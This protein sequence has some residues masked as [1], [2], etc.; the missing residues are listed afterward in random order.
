MIHLN[1]TYFHLTIIAKYICMSIMEKFQKEKIY[2]ELFPFLN[3]KIFTCFFFHLDFYASGTHMLFRSQC[4]PWLFM[5]LQV[6]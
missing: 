3:V 4:D 6:S 1:K 5:A 2:I